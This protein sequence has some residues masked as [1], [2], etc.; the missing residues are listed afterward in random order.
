M[1]RVLQ[2]VNSMNMGGIETTL[3]NIFR[4][5]DRDKVVFDFLLQT[6][7]KCYYND[8][9]LSLGGKIYTVSPRRKGINKNKKE[10]ES[11]FENHKKEFKIVHMHVGSLTYIEP[12]KIA[13]KYE[14]PVRII[15]SR[16]SK[17]GGI[18]I[19]NLIH[20]KNKPLISKYANYFF[21]CSDLA[22]KWLYTNKIRNSDKYMMI[23]NGIETKKF[24]FSNEQRQEIRKKLDCMDKF[25][26]VNVGRLH[27]QKNH[28]FLLE[29]FKEILKLKKNALLFL[30]GEGNLENKI[31]QY[32]IKL[33][34]SEKV[35]FLGKRN[36]VQ[37][38][39]QGMD[40]FVMPS[41]HEG[42][43]GSVV[44]AQGA[45]LPC[46]ISDTITKE[47]AITDLIKYKS[48]KNKPD[49]WA[50]D[51]LELEKNTV[52]KSRKDEIIQCGFDMNDISN[53]LQKFYMKSMEK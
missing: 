22:G 34:I 28:I 39:L 37:D 46:I 41:L 12:L 10:L 24:E 5:I 6:D 1:L 2:V 11:F 38:I 50:K 15:H 36:D 21:S 13:K 20:Y 43:P 17:C 7:K 32:A 45:G 42:L 18:W 25:A 9:I 3:M 48:I 47:V 29:I 4:N 40:I 53:K 44:E 35:I 16:N 14:I 19:H 31:R 8:E 27:K 51:I 49:D 26:I 33:G 52:R 23:N 30:I